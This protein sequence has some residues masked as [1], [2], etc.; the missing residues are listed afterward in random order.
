VT[1]S[2]YSEPMTD[3]VFYELRDGVA[4][5]TMD[6]GKVNALSPAMFAGLNAS[7]DQAEADGASVILRGREGTFS[8]GFDL[9][10]LT[11]G[12]PGARSLVRTGFELATRIFDFATPVVAACPGHMI[13]MGVFL[14]QAADF[15]IGASGP[16]R[17]TC[18]EVKLGLTMPH[19]ALDLCRPRLNPSHFYRAM[20]LSQ[21]YTPEEAV[22]AGFLDR[23]VTPDRLDQ[24]AR[25]AASALNEL[26]R[27]AYQATKARIRGASS[28]AIRES[29][30]RDD[31]ALASSL[32][33]AAS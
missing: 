2:R 13:A 15:R 1:L 19:A 31:R 4:H 20:T 22:D 32:P 5:I 25:E 28:R 33:S 21:V 30:E 23:A 9:K 7:L 6:D 26:D 10:V 27:G 11:A 16:F 17:V 8:A 29:I 14:V 18:N 12:G 24:A 3:L